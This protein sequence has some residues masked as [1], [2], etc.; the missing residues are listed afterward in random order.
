[1]SPENKTRE[2]VFDLES[3]DGHVNGGF[4]FLHHLL[5]DHWPIHV[6]YLANDNHGNAIGLSVRHM[7]VSM[8]YH[9]GRIENL[10][11]DQ[12]SM[13]TNQRAQRQREQMT[14]ASLTSN[15]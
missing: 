9:S 8:I 7:M 5:L 1:M 15:R 2:D 11:S 12:S 4:M 14:L 13:P 3:C 10:V 6:A